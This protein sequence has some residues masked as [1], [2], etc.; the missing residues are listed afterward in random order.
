MSKVA[1][2]AQ[3]HDSNERSYMVIP[4]RTTV[5]SSRWRCSVRRGGYSFLTPQNLNTLSATTAERQNLALPKEHPV[6]ETSDGLT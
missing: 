1:Y 5:P 2:T 6:A 3:E 4:R